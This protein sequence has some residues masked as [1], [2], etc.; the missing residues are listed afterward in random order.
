MKASYGIRADGNEAVVSPAAVDFVSGL[1]LCFV[2]VCS[3]VD[4][5][6]CGYLWS[7]QRAG[8]LKLG[9]WHAGGRLPRRCLAGTMDLGFMGL[10]VVPQCTTNATVSFLW[11]GL[12]ISSESLKAIELPRFFGRRPGSV[13]FDLR[14]GINDGGRGWGRCFFF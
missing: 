10:K 9:V 4:D 12:F 13:P 5:E 2:G 11:E 3:N 6:L 8:V 1:F 7:W 14:S